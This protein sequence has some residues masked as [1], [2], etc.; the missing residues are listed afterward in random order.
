MVRWSV[1]GSPW[2]ATSR[3]LNRVNQLSWTSSCGRATSRSTTQN[4]PT[5]TSAG[6][7]RSATRRRRLRA[8]RR[9]M[10]TPTATSAPAQVDLR[11]LLGHAAPRREEIAF[12]AR[13]G[14][15]TTHYVNQELAKHHYATLLREAGSHRLAKESSGP[16]H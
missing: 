13:L 7:W 6:C 12:A 9:G 14:G 15:M 1:A 4:A 8:A 2:W 16:Q 11:P 10:R 3:P 5:L